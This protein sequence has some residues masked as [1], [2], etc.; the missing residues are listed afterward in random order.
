[1]QYQYCVL[2][3][4]DY[5]E[6]SSLVYIFFQQEMNFLLSASNAPE[7]RFVGCGSGDGQSKLL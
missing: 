6:N 1:M 5:F 3:N 4:A 2:L 7:S